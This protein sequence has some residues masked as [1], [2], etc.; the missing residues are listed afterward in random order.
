MKEMA[1]EI[2]EEAPTAAVVPQTLAWQ[3]LPK[4]S[5]ATSHRSE[6]GTSRSRGDFGE[7]RPTVVMDTMDARGISVTLGI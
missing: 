4:I 6:I 7:T 3:R 5:G 1:L 2:R